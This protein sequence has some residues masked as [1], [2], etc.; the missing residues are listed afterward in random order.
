GV[1]QGQS[2]Q[3]RQRGELLLGAGLVQRVQRQR[4]QRAP[5]R[6]AGGVVEGDDVGLSQL[7]VPFHYRGEVVQQLGAALR[8]GAV[9]LL[10]ADG[11]GV[12]HETSGGQSDGPHVLLVIAR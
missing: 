7:E 2:A 9:V 1:G 3:V 4:Q 11:G 12:A 10:R 8:P 5:A 6:A